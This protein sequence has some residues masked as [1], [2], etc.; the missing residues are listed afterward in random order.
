M[1]RKVNFND[2]DCIWG[3]NVEGLC[4]PINSLIQQSQ[5]N[6]CTV[7]K[8]MRFDES[9]TENGSIKYRGWI[10][11]DTGIISFR[12]LLLKEDREGFLEE[13]RQGS[14]YII[15]GVIDYDYELD[16]PA[17]MFVFGIKPASDDEMG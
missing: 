13:M 9:V 14:R 12:L 15:K 8:L 3:R 2:V 11:D 6:V 4:V 5:K 17:L 16:E 10:E 1:D 7:G